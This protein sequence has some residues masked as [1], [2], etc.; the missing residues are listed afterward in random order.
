MSILFRSVETKCE[1]CGPLK[2]ILLEVTEASE[3]TAKEA[4]DLA[5]QIDFQV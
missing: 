4:K 1:S 5:A 3:E 2:D